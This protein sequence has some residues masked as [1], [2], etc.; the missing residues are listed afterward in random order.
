MLVG[1][2]SRVSPLYVPGDGVGLLLTAFDDKHSAS[3]YLVYCHDNSILYLLKV[4][5]MH[6]NR[7]NQGAIV[8]KIEGLGHL[9]IALSHK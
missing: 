5:W 1:S 2:V 6:L 8:A 7:A 4:R 9:G 3:R